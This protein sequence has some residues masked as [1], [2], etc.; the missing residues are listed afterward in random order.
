V[1]VATYIA[2]GAQGVELW[3]RVKHFQSKCV[4]QT[5]NRVHY[6]HLRDKQS[7][8]WMDGERKEHIHLGKDLALEKTSTLGNEK[9]NNVIVNLR[10]WK[11]VEQLKKVVKPFIQYVTKKGYTV[12]CISMQDGNDDKVMMDLGEVKKFDSL[13]ALENEIKTS[14]YAIA[15][16]LHTLILCSNYAVPFIGLSYDPKVSALCSQMDMPFFDN[17][18]CLSYHELV[19]A[20][21]LLESNEAVYVQTL[22]E[23]ME[24]SDIQTSALKTYLLSLMN[25]QVKVD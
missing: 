17:F 3:G 15:M 13:E 11:D 10:M 5:L 21:D 18:S 14:K 6:L 12:T 1:R 7:F 25:Q 20:F 19:Q 8:D 2:V 23:K 22:E 4:K 24:N 16:R 9:R